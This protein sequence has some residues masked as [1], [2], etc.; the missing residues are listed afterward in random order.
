MMQNGSS[1]PAPGPRVKWVR[2]STELL[3]ELGDWSEPVQVQIV[4]DKD[5]ILEMVFRRV[6]R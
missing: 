5:N 2:V 6:D 3:A 1:L 4:E